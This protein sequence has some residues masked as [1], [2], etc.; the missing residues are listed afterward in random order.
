MMLLQA[1]CQS[2][3]RRFSFSECAAEY[4][5]P[6]P[7]SRAGTPPRASVIVRTKGIEPPAPTTAGLFPYPF[8][9]AAAAASNAGPRVSVRHQ[10]EDGS[11]SIFTRTP[12]G[13][14]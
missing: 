9:I 1:F 13:A 3:I 7:K 4:G 6:T 2:A 5:S 14:L 11:G 12:Q 10:C 8:S